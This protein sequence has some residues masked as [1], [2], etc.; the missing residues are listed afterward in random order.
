[1]SGRIVVDQ[2]NAGW[3]GVFAIE[4]M[5]LGKPV[6]TF[7]HEE[8]VRRTNEAYRTRVPI[9]SATPETLRER[10]LASPIGSKDSVAT[11]GWTIGSGLYTCKNHSWKVDERPADSL[12]SLVVND[13]R[14]RDTR[15]A[16]DAYGEAWSL[17]YHLM[18]GQRTQKQFIDYLKLLAKKERLAFDKPEERLKEF[19]A[20]FGETGK[21]DDAFI[22]AMRRLA[23]SRDSEY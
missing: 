22:R 11:P 13:S 20:A 8:A 14:F 1:V 19:E 23:H 9:V 21:V 6:V 3:Y 12:K 5:A 10:L 4:C 18:N 15:Q 7:L 16:V 2:L 17:V